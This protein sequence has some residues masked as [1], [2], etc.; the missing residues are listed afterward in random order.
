VNEHCYYASK[1]D[2]P[3]TWAEAQAI[4]QV[5]MG[6]KPAG[7]YLVTLTSSAE[8]TFVRALFVPGSFADVLE[9]VWIGYSDA[10]TE[11][12]WDWIT[13]EVGVTGNDSTYV[14]WELGEPNDQGG[15]DCAELIPGGWNDKDCA[16]EFLQF[17][18]ETDH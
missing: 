12:A 10:R 5:Q 9:H 1:W 6:A 2:T 16:T 14:G 13:G 4:C 11:G 18:C 7:G 3:L 15:E 8:E 17:V